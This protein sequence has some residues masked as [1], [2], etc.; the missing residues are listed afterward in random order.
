VERQE[1]EGHTEHLYKELQRLR[2][3]NARVKE[4]RAS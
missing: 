2:K 4:E 3:E 1:Q